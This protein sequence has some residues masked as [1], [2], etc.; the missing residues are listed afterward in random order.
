MSSDTNAN[1]RTEGPSGVLPRSADGHSGDTDRRPTPRG[2]L[3]IA[4]F[5]DSFEPTNDGVAKVTSTLAHALVRAGHRVTVFT[6]RSPGLSRT[7]VRPDGVRIQRF[8][9]GP[10]PSY[11][12]YRVAFAPWFVPLS[13]ARFDV[14]HIHTPGFVGLAGWLA[15]RRWDVPSVGTYHTNLTGLLRGSGGTA[16]T[17]AFFRAWARFS[18]DLCRHCQ[19]A[20]APSEASRADL[21]GSTPAAPGREPLLVP[22]GIDTERFRPGIGAPDWRRRLGIG[23]VPVVLF[24]GRLTRDKGAGRFVSALERMDRDRPWFALVAGEGPL[25]PFLERRLGPGTDLYPRARFIGPVPEEEKPALLAQSQVFVIP[26]LS[27]TSSVALLEAMACGVAPVV[28]EFGGPAEIGRRSSVGTL[29]DPRDPGRVA[30]AI[31]T[32]LED[33]PLARSFS[34]RGREWVVEHASAERMAQEFV[35]AYRY[36]RRVLPP[37]R[38]LRRGEEPR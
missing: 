30:R 17:R 35:D 29:V 23:D 36:L 20:T 28:S 3:R 12:Q 24:L 19:L 11:P 32:L 18:I 33:G 13:S 37:V 1:L 34:E 31:V 21:L 27:D 14:V 10:T 6:V 5:T 25:R 2:S 7:E 8:R 15:A 26:S 38:P 4:F 16:P 22:N 9:S